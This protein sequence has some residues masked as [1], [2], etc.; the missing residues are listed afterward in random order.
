MSTN[1]Q[2]SHS[3][4]IP[5]DVQDVS[6]GYHTFRELYAHRC[7]L[8]AALAQAYPHLAWRSRLHADGSGYDGWF[9]AGMRLPDAEGVARQ[10]TYHLPDSD[11]VLFDGVV[12]LDRAP[13]WDG[14]T[15]SDV[16]QRLRDWMFDVILTVP[17]P[18]PTGATTE[19]G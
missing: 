6:D 18:A 10:I 15:P 8:F 13:E 11:W 9:I 5:G 12:V 4:T 3:L 2:I 16:V 17:T 14:H 1:N 19:E 7:I